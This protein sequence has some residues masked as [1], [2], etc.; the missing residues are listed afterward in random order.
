MK[1]HI[2]NFKFLIDTVIAYRILDQRRGGGEKGICG[3][4]GGKK[5]RKNGEKRNE[6]K[7]ADKKKIRIK[8]LGEIAI[9]NPK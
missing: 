8:Y 7:K 6:R 2:S 1:I 4:E 9:K 5:E 3:E